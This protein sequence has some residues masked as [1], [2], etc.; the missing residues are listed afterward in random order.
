MT[1]GN[2]NDEIAHTC[3]NF[4]TLIQNETSHFGGEYAKGSQHHS[5]LHFYDGSRPDIKVVSAT[6]TNAYP[7]TR[8]HRTLAMIKLDGF[9]KPLLLDLFRIRSD[10]KN[11]YDLP[12][13]F[14]GQVIDV[15]FEYDTPAVL[16]PLGTD[17]GYQHLYLEGEGAA[18]RENHRF[19]WM[20]RGRFYT[21]TS[22]T[23]EADQLLFTR[24]GANDPAFNL[25]RDAALMLRR[26]NAAN[27]V[28]ASVIEAHGSYSPV[29]ELSLNSRSNIARLKVAHDDDRYTA[30]VLEDLA[31]R[32]VVF[33]QSND[34]ARPESSHRLELEGGAF[35][36]VGPYTLAS[37]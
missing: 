6:E 24:I 19:A 8:L 37:F 26:E 20:N 36:W 4:N 10:A 31:G 16:R 22:A 14:R 35:H 1:L 23:Q 21:W 28:F 30:V 34:D 11:Q 29:T 27:T 17:N 18:S 7:G 9:E 15:D 3:E 12:Y 13:Y 32:N 33:I 25:R 5:D 2:N